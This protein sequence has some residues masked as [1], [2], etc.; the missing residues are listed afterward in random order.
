M[1]FAIM[2]KISSKSEAEKQFIIQQ[3]DIVVYTSAQQKLLLINVSQNAS[4]RLKVTKITEKCQITDKLMVVF[5]DAKKE[6]KQKILSLPYF[7]DSKL[8]LITLRKS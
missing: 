1:K 6:S 4:N 7:N 2:L 5:D 3:K 8:F